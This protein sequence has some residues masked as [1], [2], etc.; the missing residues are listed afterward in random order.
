MD[1][2][3]G[4]ICNIKTDEDN[5]KKDMNMCKNCYNIE[6]KKYNQN[7]FSRNDKK[8]TKYNSLIL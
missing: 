7:I 8:K 3:K 6:R 1:V 2:K 4:T 5:F